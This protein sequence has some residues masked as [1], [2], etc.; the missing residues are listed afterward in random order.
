M[1]ASFVTI[2]PELPAVRC[3][4]TVGSSNVEP[5][6]I[7]PGKLSVATPF[8]TEMVGGVEPRPEPPARSA[9]T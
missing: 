5:P 1:P 4:V 9:P 7:G 8:A 3:A 2:V 6:A